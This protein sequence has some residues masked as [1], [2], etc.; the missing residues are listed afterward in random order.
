VNTTSV[1]STVAANVPGA[2]T[3]VLIAGGVCA[4]GGMY[5]FVVHYCWNKDAELA[6]LHK[7]DDK[8]DTELKEIT[9]DE[10][11]MTDAERRL[12]AQNKQL[13][14][15][16]QQLLDAQ[17]KFEEERAV[18]NDQ[19]TTLV[20]T[21]QSIGIQN[22]KFSDENHLLQQ[23][24]QRF[25]EIVNA[26]KTQLV[27][28]NSENIQLKNNVTNL[29]KA[30]AQFGKQESSFALAVS[31][32]DKTLGVDIGQLVQQV[33]LTKQTTQDVV[34]TF[35]N[36]VQ[37]LQGTVDKLQNTGKQIN[38]D[39]NTI[40]QK[41]QQLILLQTQLD[42]VQKA[43]ESRQADFAKIS[44]ALTNAKTALNDTLQ[45]LS[46]VDSNISKD[47]SN[48]GTVTQSLTEIV[49]NLNTLE[50]RVAQ[51]VNSLN[52]LSNQTQKQKDEI[53]KL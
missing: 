22:T 38:T 20:K 48:L 29:D 36:E 53:S 5:Q 41:T 30:V 21:N 49:K 1:L 25:Q 42:Q 32:I 15:D 35:A 10:Q 11:N 12:E 3:V 7:V 37:L 45:K 40:S 52:Q 6:N 46:A 27:Q 28:F 31:D 33:A 8:M 23:Q 13:T 9:V 50:S 18:L 34:G 39:A 24:V 51:D 17:K 26:L 19:V 2:S 4:A 44:V 43:L 14:V 16:K 47:T